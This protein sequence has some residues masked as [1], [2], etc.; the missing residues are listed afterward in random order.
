MSLPSPPEG[1]PPK[2]T[3]KRLLSPE[4]WRARQIGNLKAVGETNYKQGIASPKKDPIAAGIEA[5][6]RYE[7]QMKKDEVLARRKAA[8]EATNIEEW[9][10]YSAAIGA[11]R[12]VDGVVK[13]EKEVADFINSW[14]PILASHVESIDK[15]PNVTDKDREERMLANLRG[16]K[17]LKGKWRGR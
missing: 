7:A 16:L 17:A 3:P 14:Q 12:L 11:P 1:M 15:M 8:L 2:P 5:Q 9:Y 10:A 13:R 6:P 4:E